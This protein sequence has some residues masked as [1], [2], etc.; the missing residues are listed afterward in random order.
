[1][2]QN[3][4]INSKQRLILDEVK[5]DSR[6]SAFY[7]TGGTA[8]SEFYLQHRESVDLDFF[9]KDVFDS[10]LTTGIVKSWSEK[11]EFAVK[12]DFVDP[13]QI[14]FL[15]FSDGE[16]LKIDFAHYPFGRL[17]AGKNI[18]GLVVDSLFDIAVNKFLTINQ[19][20]EVK[21]F[22]DVY[23]LLPQFN[24]WQLKD[25]VKAK[26]GIEIEP[27]LMATDYMKVEEFENMPK[28]LKELNLDTLKIFFREQAKKL[29]Y[30]VVK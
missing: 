27:F 14:Y 23:Y 24:F 13:T 20:T 10:Q 16:K 22:V 6:F 12:T 3:S 25:G 11:H 4:I 2:G 8:L 29:G 1:M 19:R 18:D 21:D 17:E 9:T 26:F 15:E 30:E 7:F 28:M 5:A